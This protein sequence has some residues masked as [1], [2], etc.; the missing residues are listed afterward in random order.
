MHA[1]DMVQS[2]WSQLQH[3][4]IDNQALRLVGGTTLL[5]KP[6]H[7]SVMFIRT[8]YV[9]MYDE[10]MSVIASGNTKLVVSGNPGIGKSW[11]GV[12][13]SHRL[14]RDTGGKVAIVWESRRE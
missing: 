7:P 1:S 2:F 12:Y 9:G 10:A 6:F 11:F 5:G 3:A 14:L 8:D 13:F 4:T